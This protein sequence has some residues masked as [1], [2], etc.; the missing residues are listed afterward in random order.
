[1]SFRTGNGAPSRRLYVGKS[2][3]ADEDPPRL[4]DDGVELFCRNPEIVG[5]EA[6]DLRFACSFHDEQHARPSSVPARGPA[7]R[8]TRSSASLFMKAAWSFT[9]G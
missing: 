4:D 9:A 5:K 2:S 6:V 7:T 1:M 8:T 3:G